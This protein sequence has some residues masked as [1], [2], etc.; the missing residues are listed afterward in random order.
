MRSLTEAILYHTARAL[1]NLNCARAIQ[2]EHFLHESGLTSRRIDLELATESSPALFAIGLKTNIKLMKHLCLEVDIDAKWNELPGSVREAILCRVLG[3][4]VSVTRELCQWI[5]LSGNDLQ[6]SDFHVGLCLV[7]FQK[8][9]ERQESIPDSTESYSVRLIAPE[10]KCGPV[11]TSPP[12]YTFIWRIYDA[13][14]SFPAELSR[15][16]GILSGAGSDVEREIWYGLRHFYGRDAIAGAILFTWR[17][18]RLVMNLWVF[19]LLIYH[20]KALVNISRLAKKGASR[21]LLKNSIVVELPRKTITGF[22]T[23]ND[24]GS[25]TLEI[26]DGH[27]TERPLNM[28]PVSKATYNDHCRLTGRSDKSATGS[29]DSTYSY[30]DGESSRWPISKETVD[31]QNKKQCFY[32]NHGR[33]THGTI[34]FGPK[35]YNFIYFYKS[36]PKN[37]TEVLKAEFR[38]AEVPCIDSLTVC[39]G[40]PLRLDSQENLDWT[41]SD[42]VCRV[43]RKIGGK[44]YITT[45]DYQHRWDPVMMTVM[46]EGNIKTAIAKPPQVF[47]QEEELLRRPVD[48]SFDND[49]MFIHHRQNHIRRIQSFSSNNNSSPL[50]VSLLNPAAWSYWRKKVVYRRVPTWWLRTELWNNWLKTGSLDGITACWMDELILREEPLLKKYWSARGAGRLTAAKKELDAHID[51]IVSAIEIEKDVSEVC[52]LPIKSA[53]LYAMGLG[54]DSN[55]MTTRPQDC[56]KDTKDRISVIFNDIGCWPESPGGVSNCRRDLVNGHSTIRNHVL[57]ESATDYGIPRFQVEKNVQSLKILPLWGLDRKTPN[58]GVIDNLLQSEVDRKIH[59]TDVRRDIVGTF[60]PLLKAFVKGARSRQVS[61]PDLIKYSNVM[62]TMFKYF[63]HKDYNDTW[64]SK[65]VASAWVE[66]WL[67]PYDD[68]PNIIN[69]SEYFDLERPTMSDFRDSLGIYSSYFF[70]F[71]VQTPETENCPKVF[72]STH[73]GISSLFG[74]LLKYRRGATFGIWDHAIL[75]R[76]CCLNISPA[77]CQLPIPVQSMLLAGIGLAT[78][79]SYFHADVVLPCTPFFNPVWE[80]EIGTDRGRLANRK[81]FSRKIDPI[82]NGVSNMDAFHPVDKIRSE[83]PTVVML[84]NIQ[85]IKDIKTAILAADVIINKYGFKD[86]K[87]VIYGSQDREPSYTIAMAKLIAHH[88]LTGRVVL[89]GFGNPQDALKDAWLFM[90]SS[91]SEGL[92]LAIAEAA[93]AGVPIVATAVGGTALVLTD[94]DDLDQKFGEVVP[95]NDPVALARAQISILAMVG[96]WA[97]FTGEVPKRQSVPQSLMLPDVLRE[98]DV[99]QLTRRMYDKVEYRRKLGMLSR[100]VVLRSFHGKRYLREHEQMYWIQWHM[101]AMR[102]D[103]ELI[104]STTA[105]FRFGAQP[106]LHCAREDGEAEDAVEGILV[107]GEKNSGLQRKKSVRWQEFHSKTYTGKRLSKRGVHVEER[108]VSL[109]ATV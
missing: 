24:Q 63:E 55:Q 37:S 95:P 10:L 104:E 7:V 87:L 59:N 107:Q 53:D 82:I 30:P 33:V 3:D 105:S 43:I 85:F 51:Q 27:L 57:A 56:F 91:L 92:P 42:R 65:E 76:E 2:G 48:V 39:W 50:W 64:N 93:L 18:C 26:F 61:R 47:A 90:N 17:L 83:T 5:A 109:D 28:E 22:G 86:Y 23:R 49:D 14:I 72:Q 4:P 67:T 89:A 40:V 66:A 11:H 100:Q 97:K 73:H 77:Q 84:S 20:R 38:A 15:W 96:P 79:L 99:E 69:P 19:I 34:S 12:T 75:W 52:L 106:A 103:E 94:P 46:E 101:A 54:K 98:R 16:V 68:D 80:S 71:S 6:T 31:G 62:L 25:V 102:Q 1:L 21:T 60:V 13:I 32:D 70:I 9:T 8:T 88:N 81:Q 36:H 45:S 29:V 41:P 74:L 35:E 78:R 58:H 108:S 44:T